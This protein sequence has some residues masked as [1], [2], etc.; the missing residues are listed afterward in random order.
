MAN[1]NLNNLFN[2]RFT[3]TSK[4]DSDINLNK[5]LA[6]D[7]LYS[8]VKLDLK[9]ENLNNDPLNSQA[10]NKDL[11]AI[12]NEEAILTSLRNIISTTYC[13]R[14]LNP[15]INFDLRSY[16]FENLNEHTAYFIGYDIFSYLPIYE[17]RIKLNNVR[18]S[19][20]IDA[21]CYI[22]NLEIYIPSINKNVKLSS[23]LNAEGISYS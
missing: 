4:V 20:N 5:Q 11:V 13:S 2:S 14:L 10:T 9:T 16:L 1:I 7:V 18:I 22:I 17:P 15:D 12:N 3:L 8:D 23:I 19:V 6:E 21:S